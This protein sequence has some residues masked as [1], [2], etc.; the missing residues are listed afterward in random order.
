MNTKVNIL[1]VDQPVGTGYSYDAL[2]KSTQDL[3]F[4][5]KPKLA[6]GITPFEAYKG[7]VPAENTTFKY[8]IFPTQNYNKTANTTGIAAITLWRFSQI[9]VN[10]FPEWTTTNKRVGFFGNSY[11]G[12]WVPASAAYMQ[13]QNERIKRGDISGTIIEIDNMGSRMDAS[14]CSIKLS[15][16]HRWPTTT[17]TAFK[18]YQRRFMRRLSRFGRRTMVAA[19][20]SSNAELLQRRTI[21]MTTLTMRPLTMCAM[22]PPKFA[23]TSSASFRLSLAWARM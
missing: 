2:I 23:K 15:G 18:L 1:Y 21:H 6:T 16:I 20:P 9:W 13:K 7:H 10:D 4:I 3:L 22:K 19:I 12:Y 11:G 8:G 17:P 5:G 14:T